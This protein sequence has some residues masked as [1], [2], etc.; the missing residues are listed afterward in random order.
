MSVPARAEE[1]W[2]WRASYGRR[3]REDETRLRSK[4]ARGRLTEN[5]CVEEAD[6]AFDDTLQKA[7][8]RR[9][10]HCS[11]KVLTECDIFSA[12]AAPMDAS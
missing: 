9:F 8:E 5:H 4:Y 6:E 12:L 3:L 11:G 10:S 1:R 2:S 7:D